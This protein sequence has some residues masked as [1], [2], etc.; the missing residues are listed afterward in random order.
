[1]QHKKNFYTITGYLLIALSALC[2]IRLFPYC[3]ST[4]IWYDELFSVGLIPYSWSDII[5]FTAQDVHPA[6][7]YFY[8]KIF[9]HAVALFIPT[10]STTII[11]K[12]ASLLPL[13]LL[14][15]YSIFLFRKQYGIFVAGV[16]A[17]CFLTM[18]ELLVYGIE[19]RMYSLVLFFVT[20]AFYHGIEILKTDK[21]IH[22][23]CFVLYGILT[24]YTQY[25]AGLSVIG[26]YLCLGVWILLYQRN[27][28][29]KWTISIAIS[30]ITYIPWLLI[31][32]RQV[33]QVQTSYWIQPLTFRSIF[34]C[35]KY[36]FLP[37]GN[38]Q[39]MTYGIAGG[40]IIAF[41][42][43]FVRYVYKR[44][45]LFKTNDDNKESVL[46]SPA[47]TTLS[48]S[49]DEKSKIKFELFQVFSGLFA[50]FFLV[51]IGFLASFAIQP[52]FV[53]RYMIPALGCFWL[54]FAILLYDIKERI[55]FVIPVL[56]LVLLS[57][58]CTINAFKYEETLKITEM[59]H[60]KEVLEAIDDDAILICN[61]NHVQGTVGYYLDQESY[62]WCDTPET[63]IQEIYREYGEIT[64]TSQIQELIASGRTVWYLGSFNTR[65]EI[66]ALWNEDSILAEEVETCLLERYWFNLY[67]LT[68]EDM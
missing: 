47:S 46:F 54:V 10:I 50:L 56:I 20:A 23:V 58:R 13:F 57:S 11:A 26:L 7:Y 16:F 42:L 35:I 17:W 18:P 52:V 65:D 61:F 68:L 22:W 49:T 36:I 53:Y 63:L 9:Y 5:S 15:G 64:T 45:R 12:M 38:N 44:I 19:I 59:V 27:L 66:I 24:V 6:F 8:L 28:W 29:K 55:Y 37:S 21:N 41:I 60:T 62:L 30:I 43:L 3:L 51:A 4:D 34:G 67:R 31:L 40:M 39:Y 14:L 33:S 1:M 2:I 32:Y 25:F 48:L